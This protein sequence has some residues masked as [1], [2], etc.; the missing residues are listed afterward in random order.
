MSL[1]G[2]SEVASLS[3][4]VR[5]YQV[6]GDPEKLRAFDAT[7]SQVQSAIRGANPSSG[8]GDPPM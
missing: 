4:F 7:L 5:Q 3:G 8:F 6:G 2:V 1:E